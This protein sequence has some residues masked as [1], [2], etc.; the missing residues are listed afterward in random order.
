MGSM[1]GAL[2]TG[3]SAESSRSIMMET[4]GTCRVGNALDEARAWGL[5]GRCQLAPH[6]RL[7]RPRYM[8]S[9]GG[10]L[11]TGESAEGNGSIMM[12]AHENHATCH[13]RRRA[14]GVRCYKHRTEASRAAPVSTPSVCNS[15]SP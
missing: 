8:G 7:G 5:L 3:E 13:G 11:V 14:G 15:G 6:P 10:A 9:M 2:A 1:G 4:H 12:G